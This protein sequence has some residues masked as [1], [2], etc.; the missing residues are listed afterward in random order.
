MARKGGGDSGYVVV[1]LG[2]VEDLLGV[3][4]VVA[5]AVDDGH[6]LGGH[7]ALL[8]LLALWLVVV[9]LDREF[10]ERELPIAVG[11]SHGQ[12][13]VDDSK[14]HPPVLGILTL[15]RIAS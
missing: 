5:V 13:P 4:L 15:P 7:L 12:D 6:Q 8:F 3:E 14:S 1:L 10:G 2:E 9:E 11:I